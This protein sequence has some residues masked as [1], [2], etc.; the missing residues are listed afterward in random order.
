MYLAARPRLASKGPI[1]VQAFFG[2]SGVFLGLRLFFKAKHTQAEL[3]ACG[4]SRYIYSERDTD[5][6]I[7]RDMYLYI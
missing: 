6:D 3:N 5:I 2:G 7:A 4:G 1:G